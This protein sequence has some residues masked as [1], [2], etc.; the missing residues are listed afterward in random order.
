VDDYAH[1]PREIAAVLDTAR[2]LFPEWQLLVVF[3]PH[4]YSRTRDFATEFAD[5]LSLADEVLLMDI[6]PARELPIAGVDSELILSQMTLENK[7]LVSKAQLVETIH[8]R[9]QRPSI[10]MT[11]GA[12]DIDKEV[13]RIAEALRSLPKVS[14][15]T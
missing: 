1:H 9:L 12:G 14:V 15:T 4:L 7:Q 11:L 8:T 3:Q 13:P 10:L 6:Y 2:K 5:S